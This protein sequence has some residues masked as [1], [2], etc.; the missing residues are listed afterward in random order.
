VRRSHHEPRKLAVA[1]V[2]ALA[3]VVV[4]AS[5]LMFQFGPDRQ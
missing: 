1:P 4:A 5:A 2:I 3:A